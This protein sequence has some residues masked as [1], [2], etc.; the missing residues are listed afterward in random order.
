[1][2][3]P[4]NWLTSWLNPTRNKKAARKAKTPR[5]GRPLS[6]EWMEDRVVPATVG[7]DLPDYE[8]GSTA[9]ITGSGFAANEPVTLQVLHAT[10]TAGSNDDPQNQPW[11][12]TADP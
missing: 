8:F 9:L 10:G 7:T 5:R 1:M 4:S 3:G 6:V 11:Q 2:F 12:V